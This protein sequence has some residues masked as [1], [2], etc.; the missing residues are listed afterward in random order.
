M[1][2]NSKVGGRVWKFGVNVDT[3]QILPGY[4]MAAPIDKLKDYA[5]AGSEIP[6]FAQQVQPGDIVIA[7]DNFGCG[8]SREQAPVALKE[9][10]TGLVIAKSFA[11]IFRRNSINIGLPVL[12][13][14]VIDKIGHG[15][16]IEVDLKTAVITISETGEKLQGQLL[17]ANVLETLEAGG[18]IAKVRKQLHL[19]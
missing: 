10:G 6:D 3:D 13:A 16:Q 11:R 18:L 2:W 4:A 12:I 15:Q 8:S 1:V 17:S 9:A 5:L 19:S 14:D 7:G